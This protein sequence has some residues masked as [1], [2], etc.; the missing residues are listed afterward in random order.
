[1]DE[2]VEAMCAKLLQTFP[3]CMTKSLKELRKPKLTRKHQQL[4]LTMLPLITKTARVAFSDLDPE[5]KQEAVAEA[6]PGSC[7]GVLVVQPHHE[8]QRSLFVFG[9]V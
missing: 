1:M 5:A 2:A 3:D 6:P 8:A 7:D 4:F 9:V